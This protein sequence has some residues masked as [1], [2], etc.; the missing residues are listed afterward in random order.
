M[1]LH[2]RPRRRQSLDKSGY[3]LF[4]PVPDDQ[5][6]SMETDRPTKSNSPYTVDAGHFQYE[7]DILNWTYDHYDY[8]R[9]TSSNLL[10]TDPTLKLGLTNQTDL[11]VA[12]APFN[13]VRT[14]NRATSAKAEGNGF[15]DV[16]SRVKFNLLGRC[17]R[18]LR[19]GD[20]ALCQSA[21]RSP[22]HR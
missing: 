10:I 12:L 3:N 19:A 4:N 5:L 8:S 13:M 1:M 11:E 21:Y 20:R 6:R 7:S 9:T 15:G 14:T 2:L 16:Y 18:R 17:W 22:Q